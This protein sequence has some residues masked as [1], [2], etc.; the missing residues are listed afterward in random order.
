M[1][2]NK[3]KQ[4]S[5]N[6]ETLKVKRKYCSRK[7]YHKSKEVNPSFEEAG[8]IL[9]V[10]SRCHKKKTITEYTVGNGTRPECKT[11]RSLSTANYYKSEK[12][13][14][15][16]RTNRYVMAKRQS[17]RRGIKWELTKEEFDTLVNQ[18]C[19]Y[20]Q[21]L[22]TSI[23]CGLDRINDK[24]HYTIT[25]VVPCCPRC[26]LVRGCHFTHEEF[27]DFIAPA[28][29]KIDKKRLERLEGAIAQ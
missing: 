16:L 26:N 22:T 14:E 29:K 7:C 1:I 10:C 25:N 20:C 28:I 4:C 11:C 6:F 5:I 17:L 27:R 3:C 9:K 13:K 2:V 15:Y 23:G 8:V 18:I 12:G 19:F 21:K 24:D